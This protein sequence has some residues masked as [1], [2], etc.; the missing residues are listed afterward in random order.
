MGSTQGSAGGIRTPDDTPRLK[1]SGIPVWCASG[2]A[3]AR[4]PERQELA[5]LD[6]LYRFR[7]NRAERPRQLVKSVSRSKRMH[8]Q[9]VGKLCA[10]GQRRELQSCPFVRRES[11]CEIERRGGISG[12][13]SGY[14]PP[15]EIEQSISM[16]E[17]AGTP[18]SEPAH[19]T[20]S[21][22]RDTSSLCSI[23]R[24]APILRGTSS[25]DVR[26]ATREWCRCVRRFRSDRRDPGWWSTPQAPCRATAN[27]PGMPGHAPCGDIGEGTAQAPHRT[28]LPDRVGLDID[29]L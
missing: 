1:Q 17:A 13:G 4:Q 23:S 6:A 3:G 26:R 28:V 15:R 8:A 21:G 19:G 11:L 2:H 29:E 18:A 27:V 16:I 24:Q 14:A 25:C 10:R 5:A 7:P 12:A 22:T 20:L 9:H